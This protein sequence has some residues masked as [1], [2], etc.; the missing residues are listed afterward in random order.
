MYCV[1][2]DAEGVGAAVAA[3]GGVHVVYYDIQIVT[4]LLFERFTDF[5]AFLALFF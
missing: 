3:D 1:E 2:A 4:E 5:A